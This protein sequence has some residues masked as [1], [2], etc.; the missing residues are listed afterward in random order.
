MFLAENLYDYQV[1]SIIE[2][3]GNTRLFIKLDT[4]MH[5][6]IKQTSPN[7][8]SVRLVPENEEGKKFLVDAMSDGHFKKL[9]WDKVFIST[10]F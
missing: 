10:E 9:D 3:L 8:H 5:L 2:D 7:R 1:I 6:V 4:L